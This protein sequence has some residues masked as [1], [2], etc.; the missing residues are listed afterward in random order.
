MTR[1]L[2]M[3]WRVEIIK[4]ATGDVVKSFPCAS[5]QRADKMARGLEINLDHARFYTAICGGGTCP[6]PR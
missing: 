4:R 2:C 1:P 6:A 3:S 5:V